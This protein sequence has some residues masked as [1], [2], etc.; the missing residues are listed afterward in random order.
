M[1]FYPFLGLLFAAWLRQP[2]PPTCGGSFWE[3]F[4]AVSAVKNAGKLVVFLPVFK[5]AVFS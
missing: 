1:L 3:K 5:F 4:G 2:F